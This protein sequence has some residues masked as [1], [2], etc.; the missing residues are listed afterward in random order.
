MIIVGDGA[1]VLAFLIISVAATLEGEREIRFQPDGLIIVGDGA[2]VLAL[3]IIGVAATLEGVSEIRLQPDSL[4][5]VGDGAV[6]LAFLIIDVAAIIEG[7]SELRLQPDSLIIVGDGAVVLAFLIIGVAA[8]IEGDPQDLVVFLA[9]LNQRGA[10]GDLK[11]QINARASNAPHPR[12]VRLA[13]G[14]RVRL[15]STCHKAYNTGDQYG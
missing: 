5:I 4:I 8:I 12:Q 9:G 10:A 3:L 15:G 13:I 2:V 1:V 7:A 14:R 11:I 6:V